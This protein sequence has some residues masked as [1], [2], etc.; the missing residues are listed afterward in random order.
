MSFLID[1]KNPEQ[2]APLEV[3]LPL[4]MARP[5][6]WID[7]PVLDYA[8]PTSAINPDSHRRRNEQPQLSSEAKRW[9]SRSSFPPPWHRLRLEL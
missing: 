4:A 7:L 5:V 6:D 2:C 1:G 3:K 9:S 8:S